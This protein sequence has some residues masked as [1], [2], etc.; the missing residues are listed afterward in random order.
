MFVYIVDHQEDE[1]ILG[2]AW[3]KHVD[4]HYSA[5]KGYLDIYGLG[6]EH[7]RCWNRADRT[8]GPIGAKMLRM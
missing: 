3:M 2:D 4:G 5:R 6:R 1:M 7:T 8:I